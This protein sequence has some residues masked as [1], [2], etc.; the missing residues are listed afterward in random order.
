MKEIIHTNN[1]KHEVFGVFKW[2]G[3]L[4]GIQNSVTLMRA[5]L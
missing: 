4:Q 2:H 5:H 3:D 1:E